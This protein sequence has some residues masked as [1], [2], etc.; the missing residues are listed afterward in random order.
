[1]LCH[2]IALVF[3]LWFEYLCE[4]FLLS[5]NAGFDHLFD[6]HPVVVVAIFDAVRMAL[7]LCCVDGDPYIDYCKCKIPRTKHILF[8]L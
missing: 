7:F 2:C 4:L 6:R 1:M 5:L 8:C 3:V